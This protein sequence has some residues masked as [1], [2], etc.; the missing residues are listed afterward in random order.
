MFGPWADEEVPKRF[1]DVL[2]DAERRVFLRTLDA[3]TAKEIA[4]ELKVSLQTVAKHK[5]RIL[6]KLRVRN[7][8]QLL[9][10]VFLEML[11]AELAKRAAQGAERPE[12]SA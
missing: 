7:D 9:I 2:T 12:P 10:E 3:L 5:Q 4:A 8:T 11:D 1:V 6:R